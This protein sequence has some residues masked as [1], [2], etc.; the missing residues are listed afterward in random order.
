MRL[1]EQR[2]APVTEPFDQPHL[3][4]RATAIECLGEDP[5]GEAPQLGVAAWARQRRVAHMEGQTELWI[6]DPHRPSL[7]ERN[8][9][10]PLAVARHQVQP[11]LDRRHQIRIRGRWAGEDRAGA[12]VHMRRLALELQKRVIERREPVSVGH[13]WILARRRNP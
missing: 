11:R 13:A 4:Q 10:E 2:E 9:R 6:V 3:P 5:S 1:R 8:R 7:S 12:D